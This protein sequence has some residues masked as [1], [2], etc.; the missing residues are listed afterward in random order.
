MSLCVCA[1]KIHGHTDTHTIYNTILNQNFWWFVCF[2]FV[3]LTLMRKLD[4][5]HNAVKTKYM[6]VFFCM[7]CDCIGQQRPTWNGTKGQQ[8][9]S[10]LHWTVV[11]KLIPMYQVWWQLNGV[12]I[13]NVLEQ[14]KKKQLRSTCSCGAHLSIYPH[15]VPQRA[16][17][18][19][20]Q[21]VSQ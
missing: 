16:L 3:T 21:T 14:S 11:S 2:C 17:A 6:F 4:V 1:F 5:S 13:Q 9:V 19:W 15:P 7:L 20:N 10:T 12:C 8:W 18:R